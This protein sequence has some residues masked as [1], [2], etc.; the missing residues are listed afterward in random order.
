MSL[1]VARLSVCFAVRSFDDSSNRSSL[2]NVF[3]ADVK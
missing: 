1:F 3:R 2:S